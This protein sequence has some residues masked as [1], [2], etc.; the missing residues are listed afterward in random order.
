[1]AYPKA[2][3]LVLL[4]TLSTSNAFAPLANPI[5]NKLGVCY[6]K[7]A[8]NRVWL[9]MDDDD[10]VAVVEEAAPEDY[11]LNDG[12]IDDEPSADD[13][14]VPGWQMLN[15]RIAEARAKHRRADNDT[16]SPEFQ[17]A[18]ITERITYLTEHLKVHPKDFSTRRGLVALVN[19]RRRLLN[20]L[21]T[22]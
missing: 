3:V 5:T 14:T 20:Y 12:D 6:Q 19:K 15:E 22:L 10:D 16:G 11:L 21:F 9:A 18:G 2:I 1:M 4:A 17:V 7:D 8:V 13:A